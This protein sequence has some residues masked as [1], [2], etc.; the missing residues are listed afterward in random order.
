[1]SLSRTL[2]VASIESTCTIITCTSEDFLQLY[3]NKTL[4]TDVLAEEV[5]ANVIRP[6]AEDLRAA[7]QQ[8]YL[9]ELLSTML[10]N[11]PHP[12]GK[13]YVAITLHIAH[14]KGEVINAAKAWMDYLFLP[15]EFFNLALYTHQLLCAVL[16]ISKASKTEPSSSQT[17]NIY[18][19][20]SEI[21]NGNRSD[22]HGLREQGSINNVPSHSGPNH[23]RSPA[24][25]NTFVL[26][27][28]RLMRLVRGNS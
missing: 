26:S 6:N 1:M 7:S 27:P 10:T 15:S 8:Y 20:V 3:D 16:A 25:S 17:P 23:Y 9:D 4:S 13:R 22:Q 12:C 19:T 24:A 14:N 11:A 2:F 5:E 28:K 18:E 21:E